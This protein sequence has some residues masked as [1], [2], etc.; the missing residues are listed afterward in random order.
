M[1]KKQAQKVDPLEV[2]E[3]IAFIEMQDTLREFQEEHKE[4]FEPYA[5]LVEQYNTALEAA[6]QTCKV[7]EIS[8]GPFDLYQFTTKYDPEKLF[9]AVGRDT[10]L[11]IGGKLDTQ[12]VYTLDKGRFEACVMQNKVPADV[13]AE[14]RKE[15]P[16][17]H[18]P[19][20]AQLP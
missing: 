18:K 4:V 11:Q 7:R 15:T 3:V 13:V 19:E 5:A 20:K 9:N 10:F 14:V 1:K 12:T 8:V 17:F 6:A 2:P 16:N